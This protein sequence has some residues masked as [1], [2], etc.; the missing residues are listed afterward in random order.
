MT[1]VMGGVRRVYR[2]SVVALLLLLLRHAGRL[3]AI[4]SGVLEGLLWLL[5][6]LLELLLL[7]SEIAV[8]AELGR[9]HAHAHAH[10][11]G[12]HWC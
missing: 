9:V 8:G 2:L 1:V 3:D 6:L 5:L 7:L 11:H 10:T 12:V 4:A